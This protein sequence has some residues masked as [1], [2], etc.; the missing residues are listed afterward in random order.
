MKPIVVST[1][2]PAFDRGERGAG[3]EV[4]GLTIRSSS[5]GC[6][7]E[8]GGAAGGVGVGE[9]VEAEAAEV[10]AL[11]PLGGQRVGRGRGGD[12]RVEGGVE[13]GD[14]GHVGKQRR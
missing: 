1:E 6:A 9:A 12:A 13:A 8:L 10:P 2:T 11:A 14:R 7:R 5:R 4:A 3:A